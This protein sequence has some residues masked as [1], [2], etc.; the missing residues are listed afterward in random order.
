[1]SDGDGRIDFYIGNDGMP[2]ELMHNQGKL[3]FRNIGLSSGAAF[4]SLPG[5]PLAAMG[6][7]WGDYDRDGN[8]DLVVTAFSDEP[9]S[10]LQN[11]GG[12]LFGHKGD[13]SGISGPTLK[14]LGFGTKWLDFDND[15]WLDMAFANGHVYDRADQIDPLS[16]WRQPVMLFHNRL[17]PKNHGRQF[18]DLAPKMSTDVNKPIVGR[19]LAT[20]DFDNDGRL[21][22]L[23][24][25]YEG[26][27]LLLHNLSQ[28]PN[29]WL[30][31][32]LRGVQDNR[33]AYGARI[34]A[35]AGQRR[36]TTEV[37]PASSYLSSSDPRLHLGLGT[38]S[39][40]DSLVIRWP[41]GQRQTLHNITA[42]RII[43]VQQGRGII[44]E[45]PAAPKPLTS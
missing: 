22:I 6:A 31:I 41:S 3:H 9:Y 14:S 23:A 38:L 8:L 36:W 43:V 19:G 4:G 16:P 35:R 42:D 20:G 32:E 30:E 1:M 27:P 7:D 17:N 29:H 2:A 21:D 25:D 37:S 44:A 18:V 34:E 13:E 5:H 15:G 10:L 26:A 11:R 28:T 45:K 40:L 12:N 33:F 24:V 39:K